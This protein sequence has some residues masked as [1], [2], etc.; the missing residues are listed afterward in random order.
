MELGAAQVAGLVTRRTGLTLGQE[1]IPGGTV[2]VV[3]QVAPRSPAA[4]T[5][6]LAGDLVLEVNSRE[7]STLAE[8][9]K[10]AAAAR[11][12]GQL[13]LLIRRGYA[14]ERIPFDFE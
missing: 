8:F 6:L 2:V 11:R 14:A 12:S 9:N 3:R 10:A 7:I 5:G 4:L 1:K 13:V